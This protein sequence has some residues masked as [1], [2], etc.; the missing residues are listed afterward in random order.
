MIRYTSEVL[1]LLALSFSL[2]PSQA[3]AGFLYVDPSGV[4]PGGQT[5]YTTIQ[6][7]VN[8]APAN[9]TI[10]V[11]P[12][13]YTE[14]VTI[15]QQGIILD[16]AQSGINPV[17][18][19][20]GAESVLN[21]TITVTAANVTVDGFTVNNN[22]QYGTSPINLNAQADIATVAV[23]S[24]IQNNIVFN[25]TLIATGNNPIDILIGPITTGNP[26]ITPLPLN[27]LVQNNVVQGNNGNI[28]IDHTTG[29]T[30]QGNLV[31]ASANQFGTAIDIYYSD[32]NSILNNEIN[33]APASTSPW[34]FS[35]IKLR[36]AQGNLV[37]SNYGYLDGQPPIQ[38]LEGSSNNT[39][40]NN[41]LSPFAAPV[42]EPA[43]A[44]L[45]LTAM[46]PFFA[47][48]TRSGW[49]KRRGR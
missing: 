31:N 27:G 25:T 22:S 6:A 17:P 5:A 38:E 36:G 7:A 41:D 34:Y 42:P 21:G 18:G 23:N 3:R 15:N 2:L 48:T 40:L 10:I 8:A 45:L 46:V 1:F 26:N 47:I 49:H 30:V 33:N 39:I 13:N 16:G 35:A 32:N 37:E 29:T 28:G 11:D 14:N 24:V 4:T 43:S 12:G 9:S 19:R 20:S 44:V